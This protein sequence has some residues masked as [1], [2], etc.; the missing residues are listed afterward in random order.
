[1]KLLQLGVYYRSLPQSKLVKTHTKTRVSMLVLQELSFSIIV[2]EFA[3]GKLIFKMNV[4]LHLNSEP[5]VTI[6]TLR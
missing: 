2:N 5:A 6:T 4:E 1:M 3:K